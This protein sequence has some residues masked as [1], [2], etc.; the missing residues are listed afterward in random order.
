[1]AGFAYPYNPNADKQECI[2]RDEVVLPSANPN[3]WNCIIPAWAPFYRE[4][5]VVIDGATGVELKE[6]LDFY[7]G[8]YCKEVNTLTRRRAYG[9]I[10]LIRPVDGAVKFKE[11]MTVGGSFNVRGNDIRDYLA[12]RDLPDP[13][14]EDWK[15]VA[16]YI[17]PVDPIQPPKN[18][19][20]ALA[21]DPPTRALNR[22]VEKLTELNT[23]QTQRFGAIFTR[24]HQLGVKI[25]A[26][27][28]ANHGRRNNRHNVT[29]QQL[30][31]LGKDEIAV[32]ALRAYGNTLAQITALIRSMGITE[33]NVDQYYS[34]LGGIFQ[35]RIAF[36]GSTAQIQNELGTA[37]INFVNGDIKILADGSVSLVADSDKNKTDEAMMAS[38]GN[39]F[40]TVHS[41]KVGQDKK[42]GKYNGY[43]L[44]HVGNIND[45]LGLF[46]NAITPVLDLHVANS[47]DVTLSGKGTSQD[48]LTGYVT[49]PSAE[50]VKAGMVKMSPSLYTLSDEY[51]ATAADL[52]L[53]IDQLD[54][55]VPGTRKVQ[56]KVLST[57]IAFNKN[58][59]GLGRVDNTSVGAKV[60]SDAFKAAV[61]NKSPIAHTHDLTDPTIIGDAAAQRRGLVKLSSTAG[62]DQLSAAT[63]KLANTYKVLADDQE[64]LGDGKIDNKHVHVI[65]FATRATGLPI[66][67]IVG[68][69]VKIR[70]GLRFFYGSTVRTTVDQTVA[71]STYPALAEMGV[72]YVYIEPTSET[73]L[74]MT[75]GPW[76]ADSWETGK[77]RIGR[78]DMLPTPTVTPMPFVKLHNVVE[79][80][81]H[82]NDRN[83]HGL[84][85]NLKKLLGLDYLEN[86]TMSDKVA[87][88]TFLDVFNSW[89]RFSHGNTDTYPFNPAEV[90]TWAYNAATDRVSNT[91]NS[92]SYIGLVSS[93]TF[94]D[95]EFEAYLSS[96]NA[97]DDMIGLVL[98]FYKDPVTGKEH[99]LQVMRN[100]G[101]QNTQDYDVFYAYN[102]NQR[103]TYMIR[104]SGSRKQ[105]GWSTAGETRLYAKR[106]GNLILCRVYAYSA[107]D[108][109]QTLVDEY[110]IDLA[111]DPRL[112]KF[113]GESRYGYSALSQ[114]NS[115]WRVTRRPDDDGRGYYASMKAVRDVKQTCMDKTIIAKGVA[116]HGA[117]IPLPLDYTREQVSVIVIPKDIPNTP[118][119]IKSW[120]CSV[121]AA[122]VVT[123]QVTSSTD[124]V[125]NGTVEY[126][127][128]GSKL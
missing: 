122:G 24:I 55:Y 4:S 45:L 106:S 74:N 9:S 91:T 107:I 124:V 85:N 10:M 98:A 53:L 6:G 109:T 16:K 41:S 7:L 37:I 28:L 105:I 126:Y 47:G 52:Q 66:L 117:T 90:G 128:V 26:Y 65:E 56:G 81:E 18:L 19:E 5:L 87:F 118:A 67:S 46:D 99:T 73:A 97:D 14:N 78:I 8:H 79:V 29:Y 92:A 12:T 72:G 32:N 83:A 13:R 38:A 30:G 64:A 1:M 25:R 88:P 102:Y 57:N 89:Y 17:R 31:A 43:Y 70:S 63:P 54:D 51:A 21:Q 93:D 123:F 82:I 27:D 39:N 112:S 111:S 94:G 120:K 84:G 62:T 59:L 40:L 61:T 121:D 36:S 95:Y 44:I 100:L 113:L 11:Y 108:P 69:A 75:I 20:E 125:V 104:T 114:A 50:A 76:E 110:T 116:V 2:V 58:D 42:A 77:C 33:S 60:P 48:P 101:S 103:D 35:G 96:N 22:I 80:M 71:F 119:G 86:K 23:E 127:L 15:A 49:F 115:T 34:L 3:K 68:S